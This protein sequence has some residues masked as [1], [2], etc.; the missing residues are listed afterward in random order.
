MRPE[1][2]ARASPSDARRR[3]APSGRS[4]PSASSRFGS[5]AFAASK[6]AI[7]CSK[8]SLTGHRGKK[9]IAGPTT[10]R[11]DGKV[12]APD[13]NRTCDLW[14]RKPTLYPTEL[15]ARR[16]GFYRDRSNERP[17]AA[18]RAHVGHGIIRTLLPAGTRHCVLR[19]AA[20]HE[21]RPYGARC[22]IAPD[23]NPPCKTHDH[24]D[25]ARSCTIIT[26]STRRSRIGSSRSLPS[27]LALVATIAI[28]MLLTQMVTDAPKAGQG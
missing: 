10:S 19:P 28:L 22:R 12:G 21:R 17:P 15:R 1:P 5:S 13:R 7:A 4:R 20:E 27:G 9:S 18:G 26:I 16:S 11:T 24:H 25:H 8:R 6:R 2:G 3:P 23:R 14:L